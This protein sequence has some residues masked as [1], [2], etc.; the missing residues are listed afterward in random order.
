M[1]TR[2]GGPQKQPES[3]GEKKNYLSSVL[4]PNYNFLVFQANS[5]VIVHSR[6]KETSNKTG[7]FES[8]FYSVH[9]HTHMWH[10]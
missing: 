10:L 5:L 3:F 2:L 4:K 9:L 1:I 7:K 6:E 8:I